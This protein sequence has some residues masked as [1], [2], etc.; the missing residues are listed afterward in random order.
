[1][2]KK[3]IA[4]II[5]SLLFFG[6]LG[7]LLLFGSPPVTKPNVQLSTYSISVSELNGKILTTLTENGKSHLLNENEI[8]A[9]AVVSLN[10][11]GEILW[12]LCPSDYKMS[13]PSSET[14]NQITYDASV[15]AS[16]D[17]VP[18][19]QSSIT[20]TCSK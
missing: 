14:K 18:N 9:Y 16:M 8:S 6:F 17:T 15:G 3:I 12:L 4:I 13:N 20:V 19:K 7:Y 10:S 1:M 2:N 5:A 11:T